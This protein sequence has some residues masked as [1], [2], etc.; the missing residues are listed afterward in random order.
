MMEM[1]RIHDGLD[2]HDQPVHDAGPDGE[3]DQAEMVAWIAC[4]EEQEHAQ[5]RVHGDDHLEI[6]GSPAAVPGPPR[7]PQD[8]QRVNPECED[9]ADDAE[10]EREEL[11]VIGCSHGTSPQVWVTESYAAFWN[12]RP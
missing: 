2:G 12:L 10:C 11:V 4:R 9:E 7:R 3:R 6:L 8:G 1:H 5:S